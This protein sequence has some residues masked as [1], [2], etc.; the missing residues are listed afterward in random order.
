MLTFSVTKEADACSIGFFG[1]TPYHYG[2][3]LYSGRNFQLYT[4]KRALAIIH[5]RF[6]TKFYLGKMRS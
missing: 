1:Y 5:I 2:L 6:N 4:H 3:V